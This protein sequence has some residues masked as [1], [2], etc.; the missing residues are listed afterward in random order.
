MLPTAHHRCDISSKGAALPRRNEAETDPAHSFH[1]SALYSKYNERLFDFPRVLDPYCTL[2]VDSYGQ[3]QT[4][5]KT[6]ACLNTKSP[7]W[8]E[9]FELDVDG[10]MTLRI[11][12]YDRAKE[13]DAGSSNVEDVLIAKGKLPVN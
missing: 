7:N 10:A 5:A 3:F 4:K 2:E 9:E 11:L 12:C 1:A 6:R 8:N 13:T